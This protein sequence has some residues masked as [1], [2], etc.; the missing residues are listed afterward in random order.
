M[1]TPIEVHEKRI[2]E[3]RMV[4]VDFS[5]RLEPGEKIVSVDVTEES[6]T[7]IASSKKTNLTPIHINEIEVAVQQ[8][9]SFRVEEGGVG[10]TTYDFLV[11]YVTDYDPAQTHISRIPLLIIN[12]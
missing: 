4:F 7:L 3:R 12:D 9:V 11:E 8:A 5:G 2:G 1:P 6:G 10:G